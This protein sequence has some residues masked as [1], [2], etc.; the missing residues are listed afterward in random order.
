[1]DRCPSRCFHS[2]GTISLLAQSDV[3]VW[4]YSSVEARNGLSSLSVLRGEKLYSVN[5]SRKHSLDDQS[6]F[7]LIMGGFTYDFGRAHTGPRGQPA[8]RILL[9]SDL[10]YILSS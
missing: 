7:S 2:R 3:N 4:G 1:M 8:I 9:V 6:Q 10:L 5:V